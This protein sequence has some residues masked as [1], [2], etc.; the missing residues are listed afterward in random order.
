MECKTARCVI[1]YITSFV[2]GG[3]CSELRLLKFLK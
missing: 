3:D 2:G 1:G